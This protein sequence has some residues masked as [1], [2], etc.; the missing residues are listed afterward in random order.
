LR[1]GKLLR[2]GVTLRDKSIP[3]PFTGILAGKG[4]VGVPLRER[5]LQTGYFTLERNPLRINVILDLFR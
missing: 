1:F 4:L 2:N 5:R 3:S